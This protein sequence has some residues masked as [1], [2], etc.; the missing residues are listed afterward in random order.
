V[1][2][3]YVRRLDRITVAVEGLVNAVM[4]VAATGGANLSVLMVQFPVVEPR[5]PGN[6]VLGLPSAAYLVWYLWWVGRIEVSLFGR[7]QWTELVARSMTRQRGRYGPPDDPD[8]WDI[9]TDAHPYRL[10]TLK[11]RLAPP[12]NELAPLP[13]GT[14]LGVRY[15]PGTYRVMEV[16]TLTDQ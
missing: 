2:P 15:R 7:P 14:R 16:W 13:A 4:F 12:F 8:A 3:I 11:V 5:E 6:W 10:G 9:E 1:T